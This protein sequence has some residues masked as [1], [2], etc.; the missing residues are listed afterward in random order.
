MGNIWNCNYPL[1]QGGVTEF[2]YS[3]MSHGADLPLSESTRFGWDAVSPLIAHWV[4]SSAEP[5]APAPFRFEIEPQNAMIAVIK[6]PEAGEG[7]VFRVWECAGQTNTRP[8]FR[9]S[10]AAPRVCAV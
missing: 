1:W 9:L 10:D 5:E 3:F 4:S 8:A 7:I 6:Q 2:D